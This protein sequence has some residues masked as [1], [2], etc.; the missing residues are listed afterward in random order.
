[1]ILVCE[2]YLKKQAFSEQKQS[3]TWVLCFLTIISSCVRPAWP[4]DLFGQ[5]SPYT[6]RIYLAHG[7]I[8]FFFYK[9]ANINSKNFSVYKF[10]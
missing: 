8:I 4:T 7:R 9:K 3:K 6:R 5:S 10:Y 2:K 1:M